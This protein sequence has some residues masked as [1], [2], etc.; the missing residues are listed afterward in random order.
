MIE[1]FEKDEYQDKCCICGKSQTFYRTKLAI[2]ETYNCSECK[3][4]LREREQCRA[5]VKHCAQL[6][7][8]TLS[9]LILVN[10]F[11]FKFIYEPGTSG[12]FRLFFK[13]LPNYFQSDYYS[14]EEI[15]KAPPNIPHQNLEALSY[16]SHFF[17]LV[18][19]SD[20]LEHVRKP[21]Q[22][23]K[24]IFRVLKPGGFNI[25]TVP[26]QDPANK[27]TIARVDTSTETDIHLLPAHYHGNGKGG[28]S[29]VYND[30]GLDILDMLEST[31]FITQ[32]Q[33]PTTTSTKANRIFTLI[34][35]KPCTTN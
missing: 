27:T 5:I 30:F 22:A 13:Q 29:L 23:F 9:E 2:R 19:S 32:F 20:I 17:D 16:P 3:A 34:A 14:P 28:K 6:N 31:G 10:S 35:Q 4:S 7:A 25:F 18:V 12:P 21:K 1:D 33:K 11:K 8:E 15:K 26:L 24:E